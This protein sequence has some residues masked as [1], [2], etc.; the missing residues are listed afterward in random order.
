MDSGK[1]KK[2]NNDKNK[3]ESICLV[4]PAEAYVDTPVRFGI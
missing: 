1:H 2:L 4:I 3:F